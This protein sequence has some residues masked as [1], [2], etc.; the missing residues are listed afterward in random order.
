MLDYFPKQL[1]YFAVPL[2]TQEG[3]DFS[4]PSLEPGIVYLLDYCHSSGYEVISL[5]ILI[6]ISLMPWNQRR[7][8]HPT[9]V[10][11]PGKS[12]GW[13]SLGCSPWG[14]KESDMIEWLT[15]SLSPSYITQIQNCQISM[16]VHFYFIEEPLYCFPQ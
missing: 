16:V 7:Q 8:W 10:L 13:R 2:P 15:L 1:Q 14:F 12:H 11:L 9:P 4:I 5:M 6:Y 3:S